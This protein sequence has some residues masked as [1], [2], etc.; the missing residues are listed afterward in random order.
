ME[1]NENG[2]FVSV[3][4]VEVECPQCGDVSEFYPSD[5][6]RGRRFCSQSCANEHKSENWTGENHHNYERQTSVCE[7]CGGEFEHL[8]SDDRQYCDGSCRNKDRDYPEGP[9]NPNW[10]G[11]KTSEIKKLRTSDKYAEWREAVFERDGY[12]CQD[13]GASDE[14]LNA[15]HLVPISED[16]SKA[17][18]V[19]NGVTLCIDCHQKRHPDT[20][21]DISQS[22]R[23]AESE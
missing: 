12:A 13:C 6:E 20:P 17:L 18:D 22:K 7:Y 14:Y 23:N 19:D 1:R 3:E 8:P 4:K 9:E 16:I 15:H 10:K 5:V 21:L 11:G 2:Q